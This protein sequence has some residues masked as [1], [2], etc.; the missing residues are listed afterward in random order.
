MGVLDHK[1]STNPSIKHEKIQPKNYYCDSLNMYRFYCDQQSTNSFVIDGFA[2]V[3]EAFLSLSFF[4]QLQ[5]LNIKT[6][7]VG[8]CE[9]F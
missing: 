1:G 3:T 6:T 8:N 9:M 2:K 7:I 4:S 5:L